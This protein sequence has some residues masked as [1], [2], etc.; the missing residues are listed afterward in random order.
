MN[1][2]F[3]G[4]LALSSVIT[5]EGNVV[6]SA[7]V[8]RPLSASG[9]DIHWQGSRVVLPGSPRILPLDE[10][11]AEA[12]GGEG[13][14]ALSAVHAIYIRNTGEHAVQVGGWAEMVSA[15][16]DLAFIELPPGAVMYLDGGVAGRP[17]GEGDH[18]VV[19]NESSGESSFEV[20]FIGTK[21]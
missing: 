17:V 19:R 10:L 12:F 16:G 1:L 7:N 15:D 9:S 20:L 11:P 2:M 13:V 8:S 5:D 6:E 4:S 18:L 21:A 3:R 14:V